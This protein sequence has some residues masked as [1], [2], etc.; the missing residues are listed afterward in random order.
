MDDID[1]ML[2]EEALIRERQY[3]QNYLDDFY[4]ESDPENDD[5]GEP[6]DED[7]EWDDKPRWVVYPD[8]S[9]EEGGVWLEPNVQ[10]GEA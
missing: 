1:A 2:R 10:R 8:E 6:D 5:Y 4:G 9:E 7:P 3:W